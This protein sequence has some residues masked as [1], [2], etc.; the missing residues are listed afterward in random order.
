VDM[1]SNLLGSYLPFIIGARN[2]IGSKFAMLEVRV[3][4]TMILQ[5]LKFD[6]DPSQKDK[7]VEQ[8]CTVAMIPRTPIKLIFEE[9]N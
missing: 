3:L 9:R 4:L 8:T 6:L 7:V 2:C 1:E 5:K